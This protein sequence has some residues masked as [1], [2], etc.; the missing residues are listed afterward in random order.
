MPTFTPYGTSPN[1]AAA[2]ANSAPTYSSA[3]DND[4]PWEALSRQPPSSGQSGAPG[5]APPPVSRRNKPNYDWKMLQSDEQAR[6]EHYAKLSVDT[7][8][9]ALALQKAREALAIGN[10][11]LGTLSEQAVQIDNVERDVESM[12]VQLDRGNRHLRSIEGAFG[13]VSNLV[14][15]DK[16]DKNMYFYNSRDRDRSLEGYSEEELLG[17]EGDRETM[18]RDSMA[19]GNDSLKKQLAQQDK[20]LE[21]LE[22]L[23]A[24]LNGI[25]GTMNTELTRQNEQLDRLNVRAAGA[26]DKT[27][28]TNY[29][30][31][32]LL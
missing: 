17:G 10:A 13:T 22:K 19:G 3:T 2:P 9:S 1:G 24:G 11:S 23:M 31:N 32:K 25:A 29:R 21:E 16:N 27:H 5:G 30:I 26:I 15:G 7:Q 28:K 12:H 4:D 14:T 6:S 8:S 18:S 20:D